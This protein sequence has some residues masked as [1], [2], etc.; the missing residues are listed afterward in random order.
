MGRMCGVQ[1][2]DNWEGAPGAVVVVKGRAN[3]REGQLLAWANEMEA[4]I[5]TQVCCR[6]ALQMSLRGSSQHLSLGSTCN[7]SGFAHR[8][9]HHSPLHHTTRETCS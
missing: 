1:V 5:V 9:C 4:T 3:T 6:L 2:M 8:V 7:V